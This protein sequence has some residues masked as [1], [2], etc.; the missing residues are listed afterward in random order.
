MSSTVKLRLLSSL[1]LALTMIAAWA[2]NGSAVVKIDDV[3]LI[4]RQTLFGSPDRAAV[5]LS[6]DGSYISFLS[7][8]D[9]VMNIWVAPIDDLDTARPVTDDRLRGITNY[10]WSYLDDTIIYLQDTG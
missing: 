8:K 3:P 5:R 4:P 2:F 7:P 10:Q 9:G 1:F 6:P